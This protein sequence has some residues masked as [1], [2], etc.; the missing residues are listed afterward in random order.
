MRWEEW[1]KAQQ[2]IHRSDDSH[3][4]KLISP[5]NHTPSISTLDLECVESSKSLIRDEFIDKLNAR[6]IALTGYVCEWLVQLYA[7]C[8][9]WLKKSQFSP[10]SLLERHSFSTYAIHSHISCYSLPLGD[11]SR[12]VF[13]SCGARL[14][15]K[16]HKVH[17]FFLS[18]QHLA[19]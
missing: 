8:S 16:K 13:W 10:A 2:F 9:E 15:A 11:I 19:W 17:R 7:K 3:V 1:N 14:D 6:V 18:Y 4:P 5:L 12:P